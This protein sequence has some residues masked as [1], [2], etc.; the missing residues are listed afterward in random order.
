MAILKNCN[1]IKNVKD[2]LFLTSLKSVTLELTGHE[3]VVLLSLLRR[4]AGD[5][6]DTLRRY[7]RTISKAL[8]GTDHNRTEVGLEYQRL[9]E[10]GELP[11]QGSIEFHTKRGL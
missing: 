10:G 3:A 11:V 9:A 1:S 7:T 6:V 5:P 4:I 8:Y 2:D